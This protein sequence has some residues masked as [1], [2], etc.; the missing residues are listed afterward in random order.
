MEPARERGKS[1]RTP[2][3]RQEL[4]EKHK[5]LCIHVVPEDIFLLFLPF[6]RGTPHDCC[7][8]RGCEYNILQLAQDPLQ[9]EVWNW[10]IK[11][12]GVLNYT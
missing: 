6:V 1:R 7:L 8:A 9:H 5:S 12:D 11:T 2:G 3:S 10:V 4:A